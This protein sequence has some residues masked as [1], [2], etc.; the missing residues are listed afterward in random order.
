MTDRELCM[1]YILS[2]RGGRDMLLSADPVG[3]APGALVRVW[4]LDTGEYLG[5]ITAAVLCAAMCTADYTLE[6]PVGW[7]PGDAFGRGVIL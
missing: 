2:P 6:P 3:Q 5:Y 7:E 4:L 1:G